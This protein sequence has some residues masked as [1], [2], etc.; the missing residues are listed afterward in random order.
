[1]SSPFTGILLKIVST[2]FFTLMATSVK[3]LGDGSVTGGRFPLGQVVFCRAFFAFLPILIWIYGSGNLK[4]AVATRSPVGHLRRSGFGMFG[5]FFGFAG[6]MLLPLADATTIGYAAPMFTVALAAFLLGERVRLY[7]WS[8]VGIGFIGVVVAMFPH[9]G[10]QGTADLSMLGAFCALAGA[11][12]AALAMTEVRR[13]TATES[14]T[15]IVFY[16][17]AYS[18]VI[19]LLTL[20]L[21][22]LVPTQAWQWPAWHELLP[23]ILVGFFGGLG[24]ITL[25]SAYRLAPT[26]LVAPFEYVSLIWAMTIGILLFQDV[27]GPYLIAGSSIVVMAGLFVIWREAK[28]GLERKAQ[29]AA[30]PTRPV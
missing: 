23:L 15:A 6:L 18:T 19:G 25:T 10:T 9:L 26:S 27:P 28:L 12:F 24:Q 8:A 2:L 16:F 22:M 21:G 7:R 5:M 3:W 29:L 17:A 20:P 1:V 14:T 4:D 30:N 13:L 11:V